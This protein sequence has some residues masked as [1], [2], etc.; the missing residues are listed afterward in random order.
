LSLTLFSSSSSLAQS[1]PAP[2]STKPALQPPAANANNIPITRITLY[3]SGVGHFQRQGSVIGNAQL[4][5]KFDANQ[6]N[7]VLKSL[8][9]V[10]FGG[11]VAS[12]SYPSKDPL[13]RRLSSFSLQ[14][15][16]N[17]SLP[18]LLERL[19]G[20]PVTLS[21]FEG[22]ISGSVISVE[23]RDIPQS[24][25]ANEKPAIVKTPVVN[26]L[27]STGIR[28]VQIPQIVNFS[29]ADKN[30]ADELNRA[31]AAL[32]ESRAERTKTVDVSLASDG[33]TP[34][35]VAMTYVHE[36]PVWKTSYR[37]VL[38]DAIDPVAKPTGPKP[39][40]TGT[41]QGW[42]IVENTTDQDWSNVRLSLVSGRPVSF[43]MDLYEPLYVFRPEIPVPTVPGVMPRAYEGGL[44]PA[45]TGRPSSPPAPAATPGDP[46]G[47][48]VESA[49]RMEAKPGAK[50]R[51]GTG[52]GANSGPGGEGGDFDAS[53]GLS[54]A[55]IADYG[56]RAQARAGEVG[57]TFQFELENPVTIE[58]QR[59]AMIPLLSANIDAR[60]V[61]IYNPAD[62]ADH[63]M[64]GVQI[65][66][67]SGMQLL[68]GPLSVVDAGAYTGDAQINQI[69]PGDKRLLAYAVDLDVA[70]TTEP[71]NQYNISK[72]RIVK[73]S[74]EQ[75]VSTIEG[76]KYT[77]ANKDL[78]RPRQII[79]EHPR[80]DGY[81]L[82]SDLKPEEETQT[83][84][85]F[86]V[87]VEAGKQQ[88]V[89]IR[90]ER[91]D[92]QT[93]ALASYDTETITQFRQQGKI[94]E[95]V[96]TAW[97]ELAKKQA[98]ITTMESQ[99]NEFNQQINSLRADQ[100]R[101]TQVMSPLDRNSKTYTNFLDKLNKQESQIDQLVSQVEK[102]TQQ[103]QTARTDLDT[104]IANL[105]VE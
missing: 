1:Q 100:T 103:I 6:I 37:L 102:L 105:N 4:S 43:R 8:Q 57:E 81:T 70:V 11:R 84:R 67:T 10:D 33:G 95:A 42:A 25:G 30:L 82:K 45:I 68:P 35:Q 19:R 92:S 54:S 104:T 17:P 41:L 32:A 58:R 34:R 28:S 87:A 14:I 15:S 75:T 78:K 38:P 23:S 3:R 79:L 71:L 99:K 88:S 13:S 93:I 80:L 65:T 46:R 98:A 18:T 31:L 62:R 47:M 5:L 66:N 9:I 29:I 59:S 96:M 76:V 72:L 86:A 50:L 63:P 16:D 69:S 12:V 48:G 22:P 7:D 20:S 2:D 40:A 53:A 73:G 83:L 51:A 21:T 91:I 49:K 97:R 64:R 56:H 89:E 85:R 36:T 61:S 77:F 94:S 44:Q 52:G 90:Q 55:D 74:F 60:R 101:I 39:A 27:T 24:Q 26:L